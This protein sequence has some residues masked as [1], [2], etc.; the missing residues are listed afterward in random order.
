MCIFMHVGENDDG[1]RGEVTKEATALKTQ[2]YKVQLTI[3]PRQVH[4]I[5][6]AEVNL[7]PRLFNEIE[8]C[9]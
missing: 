2:G 4:R 8:S 5:R 1:W 3:E 7:S 9:H 6:A